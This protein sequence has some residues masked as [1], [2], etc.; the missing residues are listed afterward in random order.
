LTGYWIEENA[1]IFVEFDFCPSQFGKSI[2]FG[3]ICEKPCTCHVTDIVMPW[4]SPV[5]LPELPPKILQLTDCEKRLNGEP[6]ATTTQKGVSTCETWD[7]FF[8]FL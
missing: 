1:T 6:L 2:P 7:P 3:D 4:N 5:F 8:C